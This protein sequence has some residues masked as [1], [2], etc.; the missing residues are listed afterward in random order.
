MAERDATGAPLERVLPPGQHWRAEPEV[1]HYGPVPRPRPD[2]WSFTVGGAT[3]DGAERV[4]GWADLERLDDCE[5]VADMH[6][7]TRWSALDQHWAGPRAADVVELA[8]PAPHV[9]EVLV[10]AEFGYAANI[11]VDDLLS[12]RTILATRLEGAPLSYERGA[13]MRLVLP[14]LYTWKGPKWVRGWNYLPEGSAE[15]GFWEQRGYHRHGDAWRQERYAYQEN[16]P[17]PRV[18]QD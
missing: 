17:R 7:A 12:P 10:F 8:P 9:R 2:R 3:A 13:P 18:P 6:C 1:M 5:V 11:A 4:F 14:H 15:L 16:S